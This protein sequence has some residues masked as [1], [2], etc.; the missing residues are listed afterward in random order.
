VEDD[1]AEQARKL[2]DAAAALLMQTRVEEALCRHAAA[3]Q[4][5]LRQL[6]EAAAA[7]AGREKVRC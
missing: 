7:P 5:E 2:Q 1:A 4:A 6:R 3:L